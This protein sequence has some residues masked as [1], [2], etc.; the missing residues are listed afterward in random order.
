MQYGLIGEKLS[1]SFSKDVH[2]KLFDYKYELKEIKKEDLKDF[3]TKR[4]FKAINV[5]IPYKKDVIKYLDF[6]S[7]IATKIG[8]VN[9]VVNKN[10]KLY[11]YNTD[12]YGLKA[13]IEKENIEI[14]NKK[15]LILG[16][17]GTSK[18]AYAVASYLNAKEIYK[19]SRS[20]GQDC[21]TYNQAIVDHPDADV[22]INTTPCGMYPNIDTFAIDIDNFKNLSGVVDVVYNP[23]CTALVRK[24]KS[25]G[26]KAISGLYMLVTQASFSAEKFTGLTVSKEKNDAVFKEIE[27]EKMNIVLTGMPVGGKTTVGE[28]L[29]RMLNM[30]FI[31]TDK[32]IEKQEG[33]SISEIIGSVGE[34]GFRDIETDVIK[35]VCTKNHC[36]IATGGG[37]ILRKENI[38]R[39]K[40]N[41]KIYFL[42]RP[43]CELIATSDRP[44]SNT[45]EKLKKLFNE[46]YNIYVDTADFTVKSKPT[47]KQN[48]EIIAKDFFE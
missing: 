39:L 41:G 45:K 25:K 27:K 23:L 42:D 3:M 24:A 17:G 10:G 43:F 15:V 14:E 2:Q 6:I 48:A 44:L 40:L 26:I 32:E 35:N 37:A 5:T 22:I 7:D 13:L 4:D 11:G 21:I 33:I 28:I 36:I 31:D 20:G 30:E 9:T 18:T 34:Q 19:V 47:A 1:H 8:A 46:R 29:S 38:D 16:N 12:F